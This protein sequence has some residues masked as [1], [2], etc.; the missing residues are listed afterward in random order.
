M[1]VSLS[2]TTWLPSTRS[3]HTGLIFTL[4]SNSVLFRVVIGK[5]DRELVR[6]NPVDRVWPNRDI[7]I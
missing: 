7:G 2:T 6:V 5:W 1:V 3:D 4:D